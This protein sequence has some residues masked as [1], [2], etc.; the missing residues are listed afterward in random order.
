MKRALICCVLWLSALSLWAQYNPSNPPEPGAY[1]TLTLQA[2]PAGGGS[3][4]INAT[5]SQ[6]AGSFVRLRAYTSSNFRFVAWAENGYI[7][8]QESEFDYQMPA[9]NVTLTA[10]YDYS[11]SN[12]S[13]PGKPDD[14]PVYSR[15]YVSCDP[16]RGGS[17]YGV[18]SGNKYVQG[19]SLSLGTGTASNFLFDYWTEN[20]EVISTSSSFNY[21]VK[22][23]DTYLVAHFEYSPSN[24]S[25]PPTVQLTHKLY[26]SAS[27]AEG[28]WVS[29]ESGIHHPV[30]EAIEI[31]AHAQNG[32]SFVYWTENDSIIGTESR[33][34]YSMPD[35]KAALQAH[36]VRQ[37]YN[38][39]NPS[40]PGAVTEE[41]HAIYGMTEN[42]LR[43]ETIWYPVWL[44]NSTPAMNM[45]IDL[46]FPE[47]FVVDT[48][49]ARLSSRGGNH[50]LEKIDMG[51]NTWRMRVR[52][53]DLLT[54]DNGPVIEIPVTV[55]EEAPMGSNYLV[56][57]TH[58]VVMRQDSSQIPVTVRSG[59]IYV[60]QVYEDQLVA[61]FSYDKYQTRVA[62]KNRSA[63]QVQSCLWDFGDGSVSTAMHPLHVYSAPGPYTVRLTIQGAN[64]Q[65][66]METAIVLNDTVTWKA[67]GTF[68]IDPTLVSSRNFTSFS[69]LVSTLLEAEVTGNIVVNIAT[70]QELSYD[71]DAVGYA[72]LSS[73]LD[74][75]RRS[76]HT[77]TFRS[78]GQGRA[79]VLSMGTAEQHSTQAMQQWWE[80]LDI[81]SWLNIETHLYGIWLDF[82]QWKSLRS[83][84]VSQGT[85]TQPV[86][87]SRIAPA[88]SYSWIQTPQSQ[89]IT[90]AVLQGTQKIPSMSLS[91]EGEGAND[92][93]Y[94][95]T[96]TLNGREFCQF[97]HTI[98]VAP[99]LVGLFNELTPA[100]QAL[101]DMTTFTFSWDRILNAKFY[102]Y[103]WD[104]LNTPATEP[105][106]SGTEAYQWSTSGFC[107]FGHSYK[108]V[109]VAVNGEQ[110]L[111][112][113]TMS[114]SIRSL[115]NLHVASV[116]CAD[117]EAEGKLTVQWEV[118]NDGKGHTGSQQWI[119]RVWMIPDVYA[120]TSGE[121]NP[122][123][124][125][126]LDNVKA[127]DINESYI[128]SMEVT[129][130]KEVYG[131]VYIVVTADMYN[132]QEIEWSAVG[133]SVPN[134]YQ[135]STSGSGYRYLY[136]KTNA[137][138]NLVYE[139]DETPE[140]SDNFF[141]TRLLMSMP[142][143]PDLQIT[144]IEAEPLVLSEYAFSDGTPDRDAMR[145]RTPLTYA[146]LANV[147]DWYSGKRVKVKAVIENKGT[148]P[149]N[150]QSWRNG[151]W[152]S[153]SANRETAPMMLLS[154]RSTL[155][156]T[157]EPNDTVSVTLYADI[158]YTWEG[159]TVFHVMAD[160]DGIVG[161]FANTPNNWWQTDTIIVQ[162]T[163]GADLVPE[164]LQVPS[165]WLVGQDM[166]L[167]YSVRNAGAGIPYRNEWTDKVW[168]S[169]SADGLN[170]RAS[171]IA[172][173]Y[174]NGSFRGERYEGDNYTVSQPIRTNDIR[175]G[176]YYIYVQV[177]A[178]G[179]GHVICSDT[180]RFVKP[181]MMISHFSVSRDTI[182]TGDQVAIT[183]KIK[184]VGVVDITNEHI[185][186]NLYAT[187]NQDGSNA[188]HLTTI[189][190]D[191]SIPVGGEKTLRA[192][193]TVP[194]L[195]WLEGIQ[196][197]LIKMEPNLTSSLVKTYCVYTEE[198]PTAS[199]QGQALA[200]SDVN[201]PVEL[202]ADSTATVIFRIKSIGAQRITQDVAKELYLAPRFS[203]QADGNIPLQIISAS[204]STA[205]LR[206]GASVMVTLRFR[207]PANLMGGEYDL[208]ILCDR[209]NVIH[210]KNTDKNRES[211]S[212][213]VY[214]RL[215]DPVIMNVSVSDTVFTEQP[216]TIRF[217]WRNIGTWKNE[218]FNTRV[219]LSKSQAY[220][221]SGNIWLT[222]VPCD[223][224]NP[225]EKKSYSC[226]IQLEDKRAGKWY[227][228]LVPEWN[229]HA[230][231]S[232]SAK[233]LS[234]GV[235]VELSSLPDLTLPSVLA[236]DTWTA[237]ETVEISF[238]VENNSDIAT[239]QSR[240][241][242]DFWL[243]PSSKLDL[244]NATKLGART[245]SGTLEGHQSYEASVSYAIP[246][247][248]HGNY[249]LYVRTD[250]TDAIVEENEDNNFKAI[251]IYIRDAN[252]RPADLVVTNLSVPGMIYAGEPV[253][254]TYTI[255]NQGEFEADGNLRDILYL[256]A[257]GQWDTGD[258]MVGVV[259]GPVHLAPG[260]QV[261]RTATGIVSGVVSGS[262]YPLLRTN[263]TRA[264][265]ES[266]Y[267]NNLISS[268][269]LQ[270][271]FHVLEVG[272]EMAVNTSASLRMTVQESDNQSMLV[273]LNHPEGKAVGLYVSAADVP[274]TAR[275]EW[276]SAKL[277]TNRQE[278]ILSNM[279]AGTYYILAQDNEASMQTDG[280]AFSLD[281]W[282]APQGADMTIKAE[283]VEFG[284]TSLDLTQGGNGGWVTTGVNGA[285]FDSIMDFR[286]ISSDNHMLPAEV[287]TWDGGTQAA[288]TFN[289]TE[290]QEGVYH[291]V[292]E[293][294]DG[295]IGRLD[296][297]F[298]VIEGRAFE[299][300]L[301]LD[302]PP[303]L[304]QGV[305]YVPFTFSYA[306]GGTTD[307][308]LS[309]MRIE[310]DNGA[311]G[312]TVDDMLNNPQK[313]VVYKPH[314]ETNV[315]GYVSIPPGEQGI[316]NVYC[317]PFEGNTITV[318]V[319]II[320]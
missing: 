61:S 74:K 16:E 217:T 120:G 134:P 164:N 228:H 309:E 294:A 271:D 177:D 298:E 222:A 279:R 37:E 189:S 216:D 109:V 173:I 226:A 8:S 300:G 304:R 11:P 297:A 82:E 157:L 307:Y 188:R 180:I 221:S 69:E 196:Y 53:H 140:R 60:R 285:L 317:S 269:P 15:I 92:L 299:L 244:Q 281:E 131:D 20:G 21:V 320:K 22:P 318:S 48:A 137:S 25:E 139:E 73:L 182:T 117:A 67:Q 245:H 100:D 276:H 305:Q 49:E 128:R 30:G 212:V 176:K 113:D 201:A 107:Q 275:S 256:S 138:Y 130:P 251:P 2:T 88:L 238:T 68:T 255:T 208:Y 170:D 185:E 1:Y 47:G 86:D 225:G 166:E 219:Y 17:T 250:A 241:A 111:V 75:V 3:F 316:V 290:A 192:N 248:M 175:P 78:S 44:E 84:R 66:M 302:F 231:L 319:F 229:N 28:G 36:F 123:L 253:S 122:K 90:G 263:S 9:Y 213:F 19:T 174:R 58:A 24:P 26:L 249:M 65:D 118:R 206:P 195:S 63:G 110:Q 179:D 46:T 289:L 132:L 18:T 50:W 184:N 115:P 56:A 207:V 272:N 193:I 13:E 27:P 99:A 81:A 167:N 129:L 145:T 142:K 85:K 35:H 64:A 235:N 162:R 303:A 95:I 83:Q 209:D 260:E 254:I 12:P 144:E 191:I 161:E 270:L 155:Q 72:R 310:V 252:D 284:A 227:I 239:R 33:M 277:Q 57:L 315:R 291:L 183:W 267:E 159:N 292:T 125:A 116:N 124:L 258:N 211:R 202:Y 223:A 240:W 55:P 87:F 265:A 141:Y 295:L 96:A 91:N 287:V 29:P 52:G 146:G 224:M 190:S 154:T 197:L 205:D 127:L 168:L 94:A 214:G 230:F 71:L 306:N 233:Y 133:G 6:L 282:V 10:H 266:N 242:D 97:T 288:V 42:A 104:A 194:K 187:V 153:N 149:V 45:Y 156:Q 106:M 31:N 76:G 79:P 23:Y 105:V 261:T 160:V 215:P 247:T 278:V 312:L 5:T 119:D 308:E 163:P 40:E 158:P 314:S 136:A 210:A 39:S 264:I 262:Y 268:S 147:K 7:V 257:D 236:D 89:V 198:E 311:V 218:P 112:S 259:S 152:L 246:E 200:I 135:P 274:S 41:R 293:R 98:T 34:T 296:N 51:N 186:V 172:T 148:A 77:I 273:R 126:E 102:L 169:T 243:S 232:D 143:V 220:N 178:D 313:V 54:G 280:Y 121:L 103:V 171:C 80:S 301:N 204:G 165:Q 14:L 203:Y 283:M 101:L 151:L 181:E 93:P 199:V 108:W 234:K 70:D 4:N 43:G 32:Y 38:P 62:F 150:N 237:G 286:L 59:Y 114:F